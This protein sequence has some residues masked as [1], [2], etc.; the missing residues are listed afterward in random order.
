MNKGSANLYEL[1]HNYSDKLLD[2]YGRHISYI[3]VRL[4]YLAF[5]LA[6]VSSSAN[7][8]SAQHKIDPE[9]WVEMRK[10]L[11]NK[12]PTPT[13]DEDI[14][15]LAG[16]DLKRAGP[17]LIDHGPEALPAIHAAIRSPEIEP[18]HAQKLLQVLRYIGDE[19]SVPVVLE[20]LERDDKFLL[21]R[22]ALL[23]LAYLPSTEEAASFI[24]HL[25][26]DD[27]E[28]WFTRRMAFTWFGFHRDP[29]GRRYAEP[30]RAEPDLEKQTAGLYV[31]ARLGDT[32]VLEPIT[33]L[34]LAPPANSRDTLMYAL[35]EIATPEEFERRAPS[36]LVWSH[37]YKDSLL[38]TRYLAAVSQEKIPFCQQMLRSHPPDHLGIGVRC[39]LENGHANDLRPY[40]AVDLE[41]PGRAA[42]IR[43]EIRKA[44][45]QIIDTNDEFSIVPANSTKKLP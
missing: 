19:S 25:A 37:G 30:L 45:W 42:I 36:S 43:N 20:L 41:A 10:M 38:Y 9:A 14:A 33:Q 13:I 23:V 6:L 39:L 27:K 8:V 16:P 28:K 34:L 29:R 1:S 21:R 15:T 18:R 12:G 44:G 5:I 2:N 40:A 7:T 32:S 35:A 11:W 17:R 24:V 26:N 4:L 3:L 31:L 22:D